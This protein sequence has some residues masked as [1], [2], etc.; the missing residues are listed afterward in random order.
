MYVTNNVSNNLH[1]KILSDTR[2]INDLHILNY[3]ILNTVTQT[4]Y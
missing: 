4:R 3:S 2:K 1:D